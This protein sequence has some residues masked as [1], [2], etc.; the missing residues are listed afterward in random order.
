MNSKRHRRTNRH[1]D[2][3]VLAAIVQRVVE[4]ARPDRIILFGSAA[5]GEMG[6][7]SDIDLL[8]I[9]SGRFNHRRVLT[10]IYRHQPGDLAAVDVVLATPEAIECYRDSPSL[11]SRHRFANGSTR[12]AV[13]PSWRARAYTAS[14]T[15][16]STTSCSN[17]SK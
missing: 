2:P 17:D 7:N 11:R 9:K 6:P 12:E 10:T 5:R 3:E 4:V 16:S 13:P 14:P 1:P 15:P 8:V